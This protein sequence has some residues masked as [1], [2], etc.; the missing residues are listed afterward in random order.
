MRR[1]S[2]LFP[3]AYGRDR[4]IRVRSLKPMIIAGD[5]IDWR[6]RAENHLRADLDLELIPKL[7]CIQISMVTSHVPVGDIQRVRLINITRR[8]PLF[9]RQVSWGIIACDH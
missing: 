2:G 7:H 6:G 4:A 9:E 8:L 3:R 5:F 1:S